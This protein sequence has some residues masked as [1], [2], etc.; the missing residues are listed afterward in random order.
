MQTFVTDQ[1]QVEKIDGMT[2]EFPYCMH[3]RD[4]TDFVVPW[5]WHE[6]LELGYIERGTSIIR[7]LYQEYPVHQG[8]RSTEILESP[9]LK[10]TTSFIPSLSAAI[11]EAGSPPNI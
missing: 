4:M 2:L 6:E 1:N 7:T 11:S 5:H 10:S 3:E 9:L 8:D